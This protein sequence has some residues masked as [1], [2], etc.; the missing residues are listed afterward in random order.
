MNIEYAQ[1]VENSKAWV[2]T[3]RARLCSRVIRHPQSWVE[4]LAG[5][6][7]GRESVTDLDPGLFLAPCTWGTS[8]VTLAVAAYLGASVTL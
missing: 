1:D 4:E 3:H 5:L 7:H 2:T 6:R 8:C